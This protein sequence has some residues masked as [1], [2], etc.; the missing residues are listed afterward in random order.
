M[1]GHDAQRSRRFP[2]SKHQTIL[3]A[4]GSP[5]LAPFA[6]MG[7]TGAKAP[8]SGRTTPGCRRRRACGVVA[9]SLASGDPPAWQRHA[10]TGAGD[11]VTMSIAGTSRAPSC[12]AIPTSGWRR[13]GAPSTRSPLRI[14]AP[15]NHPVQP[16]RCAYA[17]A[18]AQEAC[19]RP[20]SQFALK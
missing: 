11:D 6:H 9:A 3:A 4:V 17:L 15:T 1:T 16:F 14:G 19:R 8:P 10:K 5:E 20:R 18:A 12:L 13:S 2:P 7:A